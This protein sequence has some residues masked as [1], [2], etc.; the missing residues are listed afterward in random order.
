[1]R[2]GGGGSADIRGATISGNVGQGVI[3]FHGGTVELRDGTVV[4]GTLPA[5]GQTGDAFDAGHGVVASVNSTVRLWQTI[6][7]TGNTGHGVRLEA[8]SAAHFNWFSTSASVTGN[9]GYG[10]RCRSAATNYFSG[11]VTGVTGNTGGGNDDG[12]DPSLGNIPGC[13]RF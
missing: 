8:G 7:V 11:N 5:T 10:V 4:T 6:S 12:T 3:T 13:T 2:V 1:M 9:T